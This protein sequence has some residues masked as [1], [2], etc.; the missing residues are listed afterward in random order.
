VEE[1]VVGAGG[2]YDYYG[3]PRNGNAGVPHSSRVFENEGNEG[4]SGF[5]FG[6]AP[7]PGSNPGTRASSRPA[8]VNA[9]LASVAGR[10][11]RTVGLVARGFAARLAQV[12]TRQ[13][14][15]VALR[16]LARILFRR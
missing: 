12:L 11:G 14:L 8:G 9:E 2:Q 5:G 15:T 7:P 6:R 1:R 10:L 16:V 4:F 3:D 13:I